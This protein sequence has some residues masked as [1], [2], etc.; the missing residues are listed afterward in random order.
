MTQV[1][2]LHY[3]QVSSIKKLALQTKDRKEHGAWSLGHGVRKDRGQ[4]SIFSIGKFLGEKYGQF[5]A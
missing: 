1:S 3:S 2:G 4:I 5:G